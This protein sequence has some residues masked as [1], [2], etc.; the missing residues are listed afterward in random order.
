[1]K[2]YMLLIL[3]L[4]SSYGCNK[5][6][7]DLDPTV[8]TSVTNF[9]KTA[10]DF[11]TAVS[12]IYNTLQQNGISTEYLFGDLP[13]DDTFSPSGR[14]I[15]GD[16][17]FD[18]CNLS[19]SLNASTTVLVNRW[20]NAYIGISRA[21][22]M[23]SR[24]DAV[25][26]TAA[27]KNQYTGEAKFLRAYLYFTLVKTFGNVPLITKEIATVAESYTYNREAS[28]LVY[29]QIQQ[30]L[31]DAISL[32]PATYATVD[33]G[34]VTSTAAQ[35]MLA[36]VLLF[37]GKYSEAEPL[38]NAIINDPARKADLL[39]SYASVF[40][41]N[42]GNNKEIL[43]AIQYSGLSTQTAEVTS[44]FTSANQ[45][46]TDIYAAFETGDTRRA[47]SIIGTGGSASHINK[48]LDPIANALGGV[49][50]PVLR[51]AD[52]LLMYSEC[53]NERVSDLTASGAL[54]YINLV[55]A[56][57]FG[58]TTHNLQNTNPAA[59][60]TYVA[61]QATLRD[62][63][64][65]ERRLEL[66][67]EGLRFYDLVRTNRLVAVL[68]AYFTANAIKLNGV[69]L[70]ILDYRKLCPIPQA[71]IDLSRGLYSQNTGY[72]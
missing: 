43:F 58:N 17:D 47:A 63:I 70:Q 31:T 45:P 15:S 51:Y 66:C 53:L 20:N 3:V 61:N 19:P 7:L 41:Y 4:F 37:Q 56:R 9:Y 40:A 36:R 33:L 65:T 69:T 59:T 28:A 21:N 67:F 24:I 25:D 68:N 12:G 54:T 39:P 55:R 26:F 23:L 11:Q 10:S 60:A 48:F 71:E 14:I 6:I 42:N 8:S 18:D 57:A 29:A 72:N 34:R 46:T 32:L 38:L 50:Y 1:M 49:D 13:T 62:R 64:I 52:I 30:D 44:V 35:G 27:L 22:T 2:K 5:S 16:G